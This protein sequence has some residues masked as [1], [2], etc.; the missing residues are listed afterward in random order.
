MSAPFG[1]S[2]SQ[3]KAQSMA[4][5]EAQCIMHFLRCKQIVRLARCNRFLFTAAQSSFAFRYASIVMKSTAAPP[6]EA[7]LSG[8]LL[9]YAPRELLWLYHLFPLN[10]SDNVDP[11]LLRAHHERVRWTRPQ[12]WKG[13]EVPG[14]ACGDPTMLRRMHGPQAETAA[15]CSA[16]RQFRQL[17]SLRSQHVQRIPDDCWAAVLRSLTPADRAGLRSVHI[18]FTATGLT[19][20]LRA[21]GD[22]DRRRAEPHAI[23]GRGRITRGSAIGYR[24]DKAGRAQRIRE[25]PPSEDPDRPRE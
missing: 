22:T 18:E 17:A 9:R 7:Q 2:L 21:A 16:F 24:C 6:S 1:P 8:R 19:S 12:D 20:E 10:P 23:A 4:A 5:V 11:V 15:L 14:F 13:G 3:S 25:T